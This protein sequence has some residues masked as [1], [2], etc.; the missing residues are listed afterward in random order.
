V[1][2][3]FKAESVLGASCVEL[4]NA[5]GLSAV[6]LALAFVILTSA[7]RRTAMFWV[8]MGVAGALVLCAIALPVGLY[9]LP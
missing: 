5:L 3:P 2:W 7:P 6:F 4:F 8:W 1:L 9:L